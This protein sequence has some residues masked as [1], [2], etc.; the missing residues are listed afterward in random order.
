MVSIYGDMSPGRSRPYVPAPLWLHVFQPI[1]DLSHPR[2]KT[3]SAFCGQACRRIAGPGQKLAILGSPSKSPAEVTPLGGYTPLTARFLQVCIDLVGH[4]PASEG[5]TYCLNADDCFTHWPEVVAIPDITTDTVAR[6]LL[7]S[8]IYRFGCPQPLPLTQDVSLNL[9][10]PGPSCVAF[11]PHG[12]SPTTRR[13]IDSWNAP[14][15]R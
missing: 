11:S 14:T 9:N 12:R 7:I 6:T 4:L 5:Y 1:H 15:R 10:T 2:T 13:L 3:Y 8:W